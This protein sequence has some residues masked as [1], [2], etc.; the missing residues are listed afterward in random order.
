MG[1]GHRSVM[2]L[3][4]LSMFLFILLNKIFKKHF[5]QLQESLHVSAVCIETA[6]LHGDLTNIILISS[7]KLLAFY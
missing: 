7:E 2:G 6:E 5:F 1:D 4:L 3:A